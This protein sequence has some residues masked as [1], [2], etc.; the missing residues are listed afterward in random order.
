MK[1]SE[2]QTGMQAD[3]HPTR[4]VRVTRNRIE[5]LDRRLQNEIRR[6]LGTVSDRSDELP[7]LLFRQRNSPPQGLPETIPDRKPRRHVS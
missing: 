3:Y 7:G 2:S 4:P 1:P 6:N 5:V